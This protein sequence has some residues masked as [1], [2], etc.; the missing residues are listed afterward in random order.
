MSTKIILL[1]SLALDETYAVFKISFARIPHALGVHTGPDIFHFVVFFLFADVR[2][3]QFVT[4][5]I[6]DIG[7][8]YGILITIKY[9]CYNHIFILVRTK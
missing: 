4:F 8:K 6:T 5:P 7:I 9:N 1:F 3:A 2:K